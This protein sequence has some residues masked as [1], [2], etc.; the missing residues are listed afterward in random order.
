ME[1]IIPY[2]L[3]GVFLGVAMVIG[4]MIGFSEGRKDAEAGK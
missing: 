1:T 2:I 4:F 3:D